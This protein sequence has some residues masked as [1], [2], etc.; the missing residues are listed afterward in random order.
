MRGARRPPRD[1]AG[2]PLRWARRDYLD[3]LRHIARDNPDAADREADAI[4]KT[5][6]LLGERPTGRPGRVSGV[7]EK[8]VPRLPC[9]IA[10]AQDGQEVVAI[11]RVI[12]TSRRWTSGEWPN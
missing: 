12:H 6:S 10:Y 9:T 3:I 1:D 2:C 8:S 7:Y 4:G 5:G 11:Q